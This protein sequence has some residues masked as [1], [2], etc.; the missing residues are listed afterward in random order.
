MAEGTVLAVAAAFI[1]LGMM[2][3]IMPLWTGG[4]NWMFAGAIAVLVG[5]NAHR[6]KKK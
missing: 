4:L 5:F 2:N 3:I 1:A 6:L